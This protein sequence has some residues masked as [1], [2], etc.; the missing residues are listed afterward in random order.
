MRQ[1]AR[2]YNVDVNF[3]GHIT[4]DGF[5]GKISRDVPL[6]KFLKVLE[7]NDVHVRIEEHKITVMP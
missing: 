2:W 7:L 6:S 1:V 5:T 3:E 4:E